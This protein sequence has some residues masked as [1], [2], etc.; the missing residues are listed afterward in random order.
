M[1]MPWAVPFLYELTHPPIAIG[2]KNTRRRN[3]HARTC[4]GAVRDIFM[5]SEFIGP[6]TRT[7]LERGRIVFMAG[8]IKSLLLY[9]QLFKAGR[10]TIRCPCAESKTRNRN[11]NI[12]GVR[13][14]V[15]MLNTPSQS[16][17]GGFT[18]NSSHRFNKA[19]AGPSS[20]E[21]FRVA[22][23]RSIAASQSF[24]L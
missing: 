6:A 3:R 8:I 9:C 10:F 18:L 14:F 13:Y 4:A 23:N 1:M 2:I 24:S 17:A 12:P 16:E 21:S 11:A 15:A 7:F 19:L 20:G 5:N 22:A